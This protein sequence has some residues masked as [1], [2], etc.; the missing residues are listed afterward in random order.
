MWVRKVGGRLFETSYP[1]GDRGGSEG[2][3]E[4]GRRSMETGVRSAET[5]TPSGLEG[6][7]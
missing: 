6:R 1:K 7:G 4:N 5:T 2:R 3:S